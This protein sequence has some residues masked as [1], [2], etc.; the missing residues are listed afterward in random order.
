MFAFNRH[1]A[2]VASF[3]LI[4]GDEEGQGPKSL[5]RSLP[6]VLRKFYV[7]SQDMIFTQRFCSARLFSSCVSAITDLDKF[8]NGFALQ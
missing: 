3:Y 8:S 7:V 4:H 5:A 1:V 6:E 2:I